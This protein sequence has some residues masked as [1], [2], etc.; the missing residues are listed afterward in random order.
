MGHAMQAQCKQFDIIAF[1][2]QAKAKDLNHVSAVIDFSS[3][4]D[5]FLAS[6]F[7]LNISYL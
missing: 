4:T 2:F 3:P 7:V 5:S 1:D 6:I